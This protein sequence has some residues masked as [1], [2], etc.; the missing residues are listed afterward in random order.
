MVAAWISAETGVG[1]SMASTSQGKRGI[2][3]DLPTAARNS[4]SAAAVAVSP[5]SRPA[6]M[7]AKIPWYVTLPVFSNKRKVPSMKPTSPIRL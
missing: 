5:E 3:A 6:A 7:A 1:P 2:C 4:R